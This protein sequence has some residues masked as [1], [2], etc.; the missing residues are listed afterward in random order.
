MTRGFTWGEY[1]SDDGNTYAIRV[2]NSY[3]AVAARGWG[4]VAPP[5]TPVYPR[6]WFPRKVLGLDPLGRPRKA[7]VAAV[8]ASLWTGVATTFDII[9]NDGS[10]VTCSV[11]RMFAERRTAHP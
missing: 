4:V 11:V 7:V 8:S 5:G 2:D 9:G 1:H 6:G 3:F 10:T